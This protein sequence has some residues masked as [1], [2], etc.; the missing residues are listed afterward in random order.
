MSFFCPLLATVLSV[1]RF[2]ASHYPFGILKLFFKKK[3]CHLYLI[4]V[5]GVDC[6]FQQFFS[7]IVIVRRGS[8]G[9]DRMNVGFTT[10]CAISAHHIVVSLNPARG[11]VYS[12]QYYVIKLVSDLQQVGGFLRVLRFLPP[13]KLTAI[14]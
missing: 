13:I 1:H 12:I 2:T 10:I 11:E 7:Y 9:H 14:L 8:H 4:R 3:D 6:Q 5:N